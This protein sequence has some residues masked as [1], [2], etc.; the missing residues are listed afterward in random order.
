MSAAFSAH[1]VPDKKG[2]KSVIYIPSTAE[3]TVPNYK[4]VPIPVD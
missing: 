1:H 2:C 3:N 4:K